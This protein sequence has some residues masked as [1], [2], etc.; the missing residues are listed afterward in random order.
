MKPDKDITKI[1]GVTFFETR[2]T[3]R[4]KQQVHDH[5]VLQ[6]YDYYDFSDN[7][8]DNKITIIITNV[9]FHY[10]SSTAESVAP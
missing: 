6:K 4:S 5:T 7:D 9:K 8:D 10:A 1:K 3:Y 2:C